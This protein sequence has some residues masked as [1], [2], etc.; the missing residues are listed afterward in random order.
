MKFYP[1]IFL[2]FLTSFTLSG[3]VP[4]GFEEQLGKTIPLNLTFQDSSGKTYALK[5]LLVKPTILT[6]VYYRCPGICSPLLSGVAEV[7]SQVDMTAG[8]DF[9]ILTISFDP[10][11]TPELAKQKKENYLK[12]LGKPISPDAWH[13][14]VGSPEVIT[15]LMQAVGF[16]YKRQGKDFVHPGG[17]IILSPEGKVTRYLLGIDFLPF[18][19]KMAILEA[20][21]GKPGPTIS[22]VLLYC[23]S[24]D[25]E[26]R[27]YVFNILKVTGSVTLFF[28][29]I[30]ILWLVIT[31]KRHRKESR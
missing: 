18:D 20:Q 6:L 13:F 22:K 12:A 10:T 29:G 8:K 27:G 26:G 9:Q 25:P 15:A 3:A 31:T 23:F 24:Y 21:K 28:A 11:E 4:V 16:H 17:I 1:F 30:F 19:L 2:V 7:V 14:M 5:E